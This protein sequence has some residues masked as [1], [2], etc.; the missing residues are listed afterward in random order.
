MMM[1][2]L[3]IWRPLVLIWLKVA[4]GA[5]SSQ[6]VHCWN[7]AGKKRGFCRRGACVVT[8]IGDAAE[9]FVEAPRF[10]MQL[11]ELEPLGRAQLGDRRQDGRTRARQSRDPA[12]TFA[13]LD[14]GD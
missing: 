1:P 4:C 8:L 12:L 10:Q 11:L 13:H 7:P 5:F 14:C 3:R 9:D 6:P 2:T